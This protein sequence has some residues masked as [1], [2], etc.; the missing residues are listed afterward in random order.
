M[1]N[2]LTLSKEELMVRREIDGAGNIRWYNADDERHREDG[3]AVEWADGTKSWYSNGLLHRVDGP[4]LEYNDGR[5][6]WFL[7][8]K[9][10]RVD[11]PAV[12]YANGRKEWWLN[13][14]SVDPF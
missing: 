3:P 6:E 9:R 12:V 2:K 7:N 8:G 14:E 13:G 1:E 10:H 11:G 4:A 5:K